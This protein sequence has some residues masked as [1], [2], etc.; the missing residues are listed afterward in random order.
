[1]EALVTIGR[2]DLER[3][4][5]LFRYT[6]FGLNLAGRKRTSNCDLLRSI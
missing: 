2:I 6:M 1:M 3:G 5:G 4:K